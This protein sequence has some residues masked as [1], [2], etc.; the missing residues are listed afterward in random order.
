MTELMK[1]DYETGDYT[2]S[3]LSQKYGISQGKVFYLLR[4]V[5]CV[6]TR[7]RR[8]PVSEEERARRS[9]ACKGRVFSES[10]KKA[11]SEGK[12]CRF[13]GLNGYGHIKC[14]IKGY[15]LA[16]APCHP[17]AHKDGYVMLH[18]VIMERAIGR[19]LMDDEVVHHI[20]HNRAD[21]R[22]ENLQLMKKKD[23]CRMHMLER[24][25]KRRNDLLTAL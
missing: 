21:N 22:I 5:G 1:A 14:H 19:Y 24:Q 8:K 3:M 7:K 9:E 12:K 4:N 2:I 16:Y 10:H 15:M 20:N 23:H 18:T 17:H 13:N 11:I 6:F 25:A